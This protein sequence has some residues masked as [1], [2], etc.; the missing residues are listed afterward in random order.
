M[1]ESP[2]KR[3]RRMR[4]CR[5]CGS[6]HKLEWHHIDP[7]TK[8]FD[9]GAAR[10]LGK[11]KAQ[12]AEERKKCVLLCRN[13]HQVL[14]ADWTWGDV[15]GGPFRSFRDHCH[16]FLGGSFNVEFHFTR[17]TPERGQQSLKLILSQY[18]KPRATPNTK[19]LP[20][21]R[22]PIGTPL[23]PASTF[24]G[25]SDGAAFLC[26]FIVNVAPRWVCRVD[27]EGKLVYV[28]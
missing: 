16:R 7:R 3:Q 2:P 13:C 11:T 19:W 6:T 18:G 27:D 22:V 5:R 20:P 12:A 17:H 25:R 21:R 8:E 23:P 4:Q 1:L 10:R 9:I 28:T 14:H 26:P 15:I 24:I